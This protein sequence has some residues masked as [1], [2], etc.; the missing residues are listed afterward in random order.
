MTRLERRRIEKEKQRRKMTVGALSS[1]V[2]GTMALAGTVGTTAN[3]TNKKVSAATTELTETVTVETV[4]EDSVVATE[5][6]AEAVANETIAVE[7][8][9]EETIA[10]NN[11][12]IFAAEAIN[13]EAINEVIT[14]SFKNPSF[15][16]EFGV[17]ENAPSYDESVSREDKVLDKMYKG[18]T[19]SY[20]SYLPLKDIIGDNAPMNDFFFY[21]LGEEYYNFDF[22]VIEIFRVDSDCLTVTSDTIK[23]NNIKR[24]ISFD[25]KSQLIQASGKTEAELAEIYRWFEG[26]LPFVDKLIEGH[27]SNIEMAMLEK[28]STQAFKELMMEK[29]FLHLDMEG[30]SPVW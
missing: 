4:I 17:I 21:A 24:S 28:T 23:I 27:L 26:S 22:E 16:G 2:I 8:A 3:A 20:T 12:E 1:M 11:E 15:E 25:A 14:S 18:V 30:F 9:I 10:V 13:E 29:V 5:V 7:T 6:T 19:H